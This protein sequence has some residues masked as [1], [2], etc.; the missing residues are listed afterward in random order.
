M[1]RKERRQI[2]LP[3]SEPISQSPSPRL[4]KE[5]RRTVLTSSEILERN[6]EKLL[7]LE[8]HVNSLYDQKVYHS[9]SKSWCDPIPIERK[10]ETVQSFL[11]EMM[12]E[13][14]LQTETCVVCYMKKSLNELTSI[15]W[16]SEFSAPMREQLEPILRC[17]NCFPR[18]DSL[19]TVCKICLKSIKR[20]KIPKTCTGNN[21]YVGCEHLFPVALENLTPIEEKLIGINA[22]YGYITKFNVNKTKIEGV[23]YRKHVKGHITVFPND[24]DKLASTVLPHPLLATLENVHV[25]WTGPNKPC[26][27]DVSKL[28][29]VRKS[30]IFNA[31]SWLIHNNPLYRDI[32]I[33]EREIE[34]WEYEENSD[35]PIILMNRLEE[36]QETAPEKICTDQYVPKE[37]GDAL[38]ETV[39]EKTMDELIEEM[40]CSNEKQNT[41]N[42]HDLFSDSIVEEQ[43]DSSGMFP[44]DQSSSILDQSKIDFI[45]G[46]L[47]PGSDRNTLGDVTVGE[48]GQRPYVRI[49]HG[50][51]FA[52]TLEKDFFPKTFPTLFPYGRGGPRSV[53]D[54]AVNH[55]LKQW[56]RTMLQRHGGRFAKH[57]VF[58]FFVFNKLVRASNR[59]VSMARM[60]KATFRKLETLYDGLNIEKLRNASEE[61]RK[62]GRTTDRD[63]N[64]LLRELS[65]YGYAQPMSNDTRLEMRRKINSLCIYT[66]LPSIWFTINPNDINNPIKLI[67]AAGRH[68]DRARARELLRNLKNGLELTSLSIND[69]VSSAM[70]FFREITL[71]FKH[72]V[73]TGQD[74]VYGRVSHYYGAVETNERGSLHLHGFLW[75]EGNDDQ[76]NLV[77]DMSN[78]DNEAYKRKVESYID[79]VFSECLDESEG[80]E[81]RKTRKVTE[82][83]TELIHDY[84]FLKETFEAESNFAA[85]CSQIHTHSP[86]CLK[87]FVKEISSGS[88]DRE[89]RH[90]CR[91][92][93]PWKIVDK[94]FFTEEGLLEVKRNH[95]MVNRYNKC[96][97]IALRH[98]HDISMILTRKQGLALVFYGTNYAT[99]L[100]TPMWRRMTFAA[101]IYREINER[102]DS[103]SEKTS[104]DRTREFLLRVANRVFTERELSS[105]E[106]ANHLLGYETDYTNVKYWSYVKLSSLYA[107]IAYRWRHLKSLLEDLQG[108]ESEEEPLCVRN[109]GYQLSSFDA[110]RYRG[111]LFQHLCF[112]DYLSFV[113]IVNMKS[114]SKDEIIEIVEFDNQSEL[115]KGWGQQIRPHSQIPVVVLH[116]ELKDDHDET[117]PNLVKR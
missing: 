81:I 107:I 24:I 27:E 8:A 21:M 114:L 43:F 82:V 58:L 105:V 11:K 38:R 68:R 4:R 45:T 28:L 55:T 67:L 66:G 10:V 65:I 6:R 61:M 53:G 100:N 63:I 71:F 69:P 62:S 14:D 104:T 103:N 90:P 41:E 70:F 49:S 7:R 23:T 42:E 35:V 34:S 97:A 1:S 20:R 85:F 108:H 79:D 3:V 32:R 98:N 110:Y 36:E 88:I 13:D 12:D 44:L 99:K 109:R 30:K 29:S 54:Q 15:S 113:K 91:F 9:S 46:A 16:R 5:R 84:S 60:K 31:L 94:T 17:E 57:P 77:N 87:Y 72:F 48:V 95:H 25:I 74:S 112:Y 93:A 40:T 83:S 22:S 2:V 47:D 89:K 101:D 39:S 78:P 52:D 73:R 64:T 18:N 111:S 26:P 19:V 92:R 117:H 51:R 96:M 102:D 116:G 76:A 115:T 106:V 33:D 56:S 59:R 50:N 75:L 37:G 80:R 86:T